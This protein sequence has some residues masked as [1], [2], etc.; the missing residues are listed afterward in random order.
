MG[1]ADRAA[2]PDSDSVMN[3]KHIQLNFVFFMTPSPFL[4]LVEVIVI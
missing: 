2:A 4:V 1:W 3:R